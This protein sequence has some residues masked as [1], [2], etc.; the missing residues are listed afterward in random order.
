MAWYS[1]RSGKVLP[2]GTV[3]DRRSLSGT[4]MRWIKEESHLNWRRDR[5]FVQEVL[6][7]IEDIYLKSVALARVNVSELV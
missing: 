2:S 4:R 6:W 3:G 1:L 5:G 7:R